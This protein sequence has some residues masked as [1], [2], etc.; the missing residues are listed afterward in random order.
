MLLKDLIGLPSFNK[1]DVLTV[2]PLSDEI[3]NVTFID[4]PDGSGWIKEGDFVLTTGYFASGSEDWEERFHNFIDGLIQKRGAA[5]GVKIGRHIPYLPESVRRHANERNFP[6]IKLNNEPSWSDFLWEITHAL[7]EAKDDELRQ[8]NTVYE[9]FHEHMKAKGSITDL[10]RVLYSII[11]QPLTIYLKKTD[12][13]V[14]YPSSPSRDINLNYLVTTVFNS[15]SNDIQSVKYGETV[16]KIKWINEKSTLEGGIFIWSDTSELTPKQKIAIEQAAMIANLEVEH[17]NNIKSIE[18]RHL[19]EFILELLK[20]TSENLEFIKDKMCDL[21]LDIADFYRVL[22][23]NTEQGNFSSEYNY[24]SRIQSISKLN[25]EQ[26]LVGQDR[27]NNLIIILPD[28]QSEAAFSL[29]LRYMRTNYPSIKIMSGLSRPYSIDQ[30]AHA[31]REATISLT[32]S[33]EN[34]IKKDLLQ[35]TRFEDLDLERVLFSENILKEMNQVYKET[36]HKIREHDINHSSA[37]FETLCCY[38]ESNMNVERTAQQL[39][40]HKNTVRYRLK[41]IATLLN[42][43]L[44]SVNTIVL[45]KIA[46]NYYYFRDTNIIPTFSALS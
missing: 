18:Q 22:M 38:L 27:Y 23:I 30:L 24:L 25:I 33:K 43:S 4:S 28:E 12:I 10:A 5:L 46:L 41:L 37:L 16:F 6:I 3:K 19:N 21:D 40:I 13:R 8:M 15:I 26:T 9:K 11:E 20:G 42:M 14:D 45:C 7:S 29:I 36:L 44:D 39:F 31:Y 32:I 2:C 17:Q 1:S 35:L 34:K